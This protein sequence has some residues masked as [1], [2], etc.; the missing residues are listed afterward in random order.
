M[1]L[2]NTEFSCPTCKKVGQKNRI[3]ANA[4]ELQ[5]SVVSDHKWRDTLS[6]YNEGP[7]ME[8]EFKVEMPKALPQEG[9]TPFQVS[10]PL[11]VKTAIET[12]YGD[13]AGVTVASILMQMIEGDIMIVGDTDMQRISSG[14][15]LGKKPQNS[16]ELFGMIYSLRQELADAKMLA[17]NASRDL[18]AYEGMS[19]GRVVVDLGDQYG[20][21]VAKAQDA[22]LPVSLFVQQAIRTG[23]ENGWF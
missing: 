4:G 8:P 15:G 21:A 12:K 3:V 13:R 1:P 20:A 22:S 18:K 5:C 9:H 10:I 19:L 17:E 14:E 11:T 16:G 7:V 23:L 2:I 6:F